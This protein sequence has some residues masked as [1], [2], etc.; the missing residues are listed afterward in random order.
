MALLNYT[1][2]IAVDKTLAE[3]Q[4]LLAQAG[5]R[6]VLVNYD[7]HGAPVAV[8]FLVPTQFGDRGFQ[9]P[10]HLET[11]WRTMTQQHRAG[12]IPRRFVTREQAAR[13]GWRI[14]KDWL[15]AQLA[16]IATEMVTLDTIMLPYMEVGGGKTLAA[17]MQERQLAL[18]EGER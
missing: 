16:L 5:A 12:K 9:L 15:A 1:T 18:P 2:T 14:L 11:I 8:S 13:V 7:G 3:I 4:R 10:M 6:S 17:V